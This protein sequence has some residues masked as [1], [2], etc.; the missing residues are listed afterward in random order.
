MVESRSE[1]SLKRANEE[2]VAKFLPK[3]L[4]NSEGWNCETATI[5]KLS[6]FDFLFPLV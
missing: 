3:P 2:T 5:S 1:S 4:P 6:G